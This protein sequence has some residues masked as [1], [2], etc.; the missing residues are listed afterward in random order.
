MI[1]LR[2][3]RETI[4]ELKRSGTTI[5][6]AEKLAMLYIV[7]ERLEREGGG[8]NPP[9]TAQN[10]AHAAETETKEETDRRVKTN[11]TSPFL[12][13]CDGARIEDILS[14]LDEHMDV[15]RVLYP[16]EY[17]AIVERLERLE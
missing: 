12:A 9:K 10:Y 16:K 14:V 4:E 8:Q 15:I 2:E 11:G 17:E 7:E 3:I 1:D 6:A 5:G 13:A